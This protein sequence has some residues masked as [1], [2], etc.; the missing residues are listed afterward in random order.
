MTYRVRM[1]GI[2]VGLAVV[3]GLMTMYYVTS[4]KH[5]VDSKQEQVPVAVAARDIPAGTLGATIVSKKLLHVEQVAKAGGCPGRRL[6]SG[7]RGPPG[8]ASDHL[9]GRAGHRPPLRPDRGRCPHAAQGHVPRNPDPGNPNQLLAGVLKAGD[10]VDVV[11]N[12]KF[13]AEESQKHFSK[14]ILQDVLVLRTSGTRR[15]SVERSRPT[16]RDGGSCSASRMPSRRSSTSSTRTTTGGSPCGPA[17]TTQ[18]ARAA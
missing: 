10:H 18:T 11:A 15:P 9:C 4:Y 6:Q 3:A 16:A 7:G 1:L 5:R 12:M 8:G 14:V 13:P 2:A 17:S